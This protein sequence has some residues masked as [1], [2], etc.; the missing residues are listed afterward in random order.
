[1]KSF[2]ILILAVVALPLSL[3]SEEKECKKCEECKPCC[4]TAEKMMAYK[5]RNLKDVDRV[6]VIA[7]CMIP[8]VSEEANKVLNQQMK[9][10]LISVLESIG[11]VK[12]FKAGEVSPIEIG[13]MLFI[14]AHGWGSNGKMLPASQVSAKFLREVTVTKTED[15]AMLEVWAANDFLEGEMGD[16]APEVFTS[17]I[18][19]L[20]SR[21]AEGYK[22]VNSDE[23]TKPVFYVPA[24]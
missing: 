22:S 21:F 12:Y 14:S 6:I 18:E 5:N 10:K 2:L 15:V 19:Q 20:V 11:E 1:M 7:H 9:D 13:N 16:I 17:S 8:E 24:S 4:W 23:A 3:F